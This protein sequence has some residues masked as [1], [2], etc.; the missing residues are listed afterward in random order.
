M[1][2]ELSRVGITLPAEVSELRPLL[3]GSWAL[4]P[5][6]K[7]VE[8][9]VSEQKDHSEFVEALKDIYGQDF[10]FDSQMTHTA[11]VYYDTMVTESG[12]EVTYDPRPTEFLVRE[13]L[14]T[15]LKYGGKI[16]SIFAHV[17]KVELG[18][19]RC[20]GSLAFEARV[21]ELGRSTGLFRFESSE[22]Q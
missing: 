14:L 19:D 13:S 22:P 4:I 20:S 17:N 3:N 12:A 5:F 10:W 8:A 7:M 9:V 11:G 1:R 15:G 6:G 18:A 21:R 16:L 2:G